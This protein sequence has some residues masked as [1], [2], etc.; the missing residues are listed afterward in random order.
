[1]EGS[2]RLLARRRLWSSHRAIAPLRIGPLPSHWQTNEEATLPHAAIYQIPPWH[3]TSPRHES[4]LK[5]GPTDTPHPR[6]VNHSIQHLIQP[7][8][9]LT[10]SLTQEYSKKPLTT[11]SLSWGDLT[12]L[13]SRDDLR[14]C[15]SGVSC[16]LSQDSKEA[17]SSWAGRKAKPLEGMKAV[18]GYLLKR[19]P[20]SIQDPLL[21]WP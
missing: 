6:W 5:I 9:V 2:H 13:R 21:E 19:A 3:L 8:Q 10:A 17:T 1:M 12:F 18:S 7:Q 16:A 4:F 20:S 14:C 11:S 15:L